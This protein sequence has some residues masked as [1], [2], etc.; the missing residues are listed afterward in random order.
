MRTILNSRSYRNVTIHL[1]IMCLNKQCQLPRYVLNIF[2]IH[3][4]YVKCVVSRL[5]A[6]APAPRHS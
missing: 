5:E 4:G 1:G 6:A 3:T 2:F